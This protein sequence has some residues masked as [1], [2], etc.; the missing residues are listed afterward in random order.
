[1]RIYITLSCFILLLVILLVCMNDFYPAIYNGIKITDWISSISTVL[2]FLVSI[3]AFWYAKNYLVQERYKNASNFAIDILH[4]DMVMLSSLQKQQ[5]LLLIIDNRTQ[6]F[7]H[8]TNNESDEFCIKHLASIYISM[9]SLIESMDTSLELVG[10]DIFKAKIVGCTFKIKGNAI[11]KIVKD[12]TE[13]KEKLNRLYILVGSQLLPY[14]EFNYNKIDPDEYIHIH[15]P[16]QRG[17]EREE[18]FRD[19]VVLTTD[20]K[21]LTS[22]INDQVKEL[23]ESVSDLQEIFNFK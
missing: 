22:L 3:L 21:R 4:K 8:S 5:Q 14:Y 1:M 9:R 12:Y 7:I 11:T 20:C 2:S 6:F 13:L 16:D 17:A 18:M 15:F 19:I 23:R 10:N